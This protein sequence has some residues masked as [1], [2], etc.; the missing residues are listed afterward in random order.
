MNY[1]EKKAHALTIWENQIKNNPDTLQSWSKHSK[2]FVRWIAKRIKSTDQTLIQRNK[3]G[4]W[5][6]YNLKLTTDTLVKPKRK[7]R[8]KKE[9]EEF[10]L[11]NTKNQ[12][13]TKKYQSKGEE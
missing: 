5:M 3:E 2:S 4:K 8:T 12:D 6:P 11:K 13:V 1:K 9:M 10:R 7:R